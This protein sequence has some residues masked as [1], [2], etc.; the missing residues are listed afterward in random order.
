MIH[1]A[2]RGIP[3]GGEHAFTEEASSVV[4]SSVEKNQK[5][6]LNNFGKNF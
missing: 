1:A 6:A 2:N 4:V 3:G 5:K